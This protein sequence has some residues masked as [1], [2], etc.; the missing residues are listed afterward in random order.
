LGPDLEYLLARAQ[1]LQQSM[2]D[3]VLTADHLSSAME[4]LSSGSSKKDPGLTKEQLEE[5]MKQMLQVSTSAV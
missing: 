1:T 4:G 3:R 5:T 2:G